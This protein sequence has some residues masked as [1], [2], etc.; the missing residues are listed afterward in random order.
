[1]KREGGFLALSPIKETKLLIAQNLSNHSEK[2]VPP[3]EVLRHQGS[4]VEATSV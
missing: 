4:A 3:P 2:K 1:M